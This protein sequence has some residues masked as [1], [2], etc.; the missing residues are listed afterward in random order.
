MNCLQKALPP[1]WTTVLRELRIT[2]LRRWRALIGVKNILRF[3][4]V[5]NLICKVIYR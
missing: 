1:L 4:N 5:T 2:V 3:S